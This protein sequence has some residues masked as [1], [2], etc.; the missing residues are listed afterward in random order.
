MIPKIKTITSMGLILTTLVALTLF[1]G[2]AGEDALGLP[3]RGDLNFDPASD[4]ENN[5]C[6]R[7]GVDLNVV[8]GVSEP[9]VSFCRV[10][11][12]G[13][14]YIPISRWGTNKE[15]GFPDAP[16]RYPD[17]YT[18]SFPNNPIADFNSKVD[19]LKY[20]VDPGTPQEKTFSF[21]VED[22]G[23]FIPFGEFSPGTEIVTK[24][25]DE[26]VVVNIDA[27]PMVAFIP[28]LHPEDIGFHQVEILV[29]MKESHCDGFELFD[30]ENNVTFFSCLDQGENFFGIRSFEVQPRAAQSE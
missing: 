18:T 29:V 1:L 23:R 10:V 14:F 26:I 28:K 9:I 15:G 6:L 16:L 24:I 12:S 13:E 4:T 2:L 30:E 5:H 11:N 17:G 8:L 22:V 19:V 27:A 7:A 25:G 20:V 21:T 3:G